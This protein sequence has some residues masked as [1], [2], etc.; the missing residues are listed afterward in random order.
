M[1]VMAWIKKGTLNCPSLVRI[2]HKSQKKVSRRDAEQELTSGR[3]RVERL[4]LPPSNGLVG[5]ER[6]PQGHGRGEDRVDRA[7]EGNL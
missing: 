1:Q 3:V 6:D 2:V 5:G 7:G 4:Q